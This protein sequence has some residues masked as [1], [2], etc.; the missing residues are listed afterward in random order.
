MTCSG[1]LRGPPT[2][3][4]CKAHQRMTGAAEMKLATISTETE[5][6]IMA[7]V[8]NQADPDQ[9][10]WIGGNDRIMENQFVWVGGRRGTSDHAR[11]TPD[12]VVTTT[13]I[14][15]RHPMNPMVR[16]MKTVSKSDGTATNSMIYRA[17]HRGGSYASNSLGPYPCHM[18]ILPGSGAICPGQQAFPGYPQSAPIPSCA[19]AA[20][21]S[22]LHSAISE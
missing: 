12:Q 15:G 21:S 8:I 7:A 14:S 9:G 10:V 11:K 19:S 22:R 6:A 18:G 2:G 1:A 3:P 4:G 17:K 5:R 20:V 13:S 16:R